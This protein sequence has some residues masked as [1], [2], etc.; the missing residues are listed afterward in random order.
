MDKFLREYAVTSLGHTPRRG[1]TG[2]HGN[3]VPELLR[4]PPD[5]STTAAPFYPAAGRKALA[6]A[7]PC[8]HLLPPRD[9]SHLRSGLF[10][11]K[12][13]KQRTS[14]SPAI[15]VLQQ[16][17]V[18]L[19]TLSGRKEYCQSSSCQTA[20]TPK[21]SPEGKSGKSTMLAPRE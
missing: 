21:V 8:Q 6:S 3:S 19:S 18:A 9:Y 15:A 20:A 12:S 7:R 17:L 1:I 2:S 14:P 4:S 11:A 16:E 10:L 5:F 13:G